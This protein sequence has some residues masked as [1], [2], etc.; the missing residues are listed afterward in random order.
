MGKKKYASDPLMYIHQ[1]RMKRSGAQMQHQY[2]TAKKKEERPSDKQDIKDQSIPKRPV[3]IKRSQQVQEPQSKVE[4][5]N[6]PKSEIENE[7]EEESAEKEERPK[8]FKDMTL[9]QKISYFAET[10]KHIPKM[11]CE[12]KT[13]ERSYRGVVLSFED[14]TIRMVAGRRNVTISFEDVIEVRM[15]GL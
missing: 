12:I 14:D 9:R 7:T 8:K 1:P 15:L 13:N 4:E 5:R 10:P 11:K 3:R 6:E 2:T